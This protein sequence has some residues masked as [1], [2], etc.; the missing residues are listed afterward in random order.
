MGCWRNNHTAM[1]SLF[2]PSVLNRSQLHSCHCDVSTTVAAT[3]VCVL[4]T[5]D[6][7]FDINFPVYSFVNGDILSNCLERCYRIVQR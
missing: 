1:T 7:S 3:F 4:F 5:S 2:I 6:V